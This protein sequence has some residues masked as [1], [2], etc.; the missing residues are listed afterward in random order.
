MRNISPGLKLLLNAHQYEYISTSDSSGFR[1]IIHNPN[2]TIYPD[3]M[4][5]YVAP[6]FKTSA[7]FKAVR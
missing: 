5:F 7:S 2:E 4:G 6:G 3:A 1:I